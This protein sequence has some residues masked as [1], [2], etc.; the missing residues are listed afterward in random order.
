MV[1]AP[2]AICAL[3][4]FAPVHGLI[5]AQSSNW[6]KP[7]ALVLVDVYRG[8]AGR[9]EKQENSKPRKTRNHETH[10]RLERHESETSTFGGWYAQSTSEALWNQT[11][12]PGSGIRIWT[13]ALSGR[14]TDGDLYFT[15]PQYN[16]A[17]WVTASFS[18][19]AE[20]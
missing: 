6:I 16:T 10:E 3:K 19:E 5:L 13:L 9:H 2:P 11:L 18:N 4:E 8:P 1:A 17:L 15:K 12:T 20:E 14:L 7:D